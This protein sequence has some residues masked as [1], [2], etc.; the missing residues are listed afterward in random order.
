M[1]PQVKIEFVAS[2]KEKRKIAGIL[3]IPRI[4]R[5]GNL[6]LP[7]EL[8]KAHGKTVPVLWNHEGSPKNASEPVNQSDVIGTMRLF[9]DPDLMQLNY[10]AEVEKDLPDARLHTSL[11]AFFESEDHV[12]G[13][14]R[15]YSIPRGLNFVE[16][17]LTPNPGIP[18]TT[19]KILENFSCK[20]CRVSSLT[21]E[22]SNRCTMSSSDKEYITGT[23]FQEGVK[24]IVDAIGEHF[25]SAQQAQLEKLSEVIGKPAPS[26]MVDDSAKKASKES[27]DRVI[28]FFQ[29][30]KENPK[31]AGFPAVSWNVDK[32]DYL[33]RWGYRAPSGAG[34]A[35][36]EAVTISAGDTGQV[37]SK[38]VLV[39]PGGR[40]KTPVRQYCN[41]SEIPAGNDR[42]HF[43][44]IGAFDFG[45]ITEGTEPT[46]VAQTVS[47]KTATP[48]IRGAVQRVGYSQIESTPF[49]LVD[50][51]NEAM[52]MA[53]IDD[54][55]TD[56]LTTTYD[57]VSPSNWVRADTGA[58][59]T[60]DDVANLTFK[61]E[62]LLAAKRLIAQ[63]GYDV[64]PGN[65]VLFIHPK[66]YQE[67]LLD[68]NLN[69]FYQFARPEVTAT[70][71]LEQLYG[72]DIVIADQVK[73][74]DNTTNDTYRNVLA[75]KGVAFGMA[76][77][78]DV[79]MEAQ[80]RNEVQQ[81]IVSG[82]HRVKS[83]VI[84][85]SASCR[86]SSAQ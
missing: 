32:Q 18:E 76:S 83:V 56:L 48:S 64:S 31:D 25:K 51:I 16:A 39:V 77:A 86:I 79:A 20:Q 75:V 45:A 17:S 72:V 6:Y 5:N 43:Y 36:T 34:G 82:T 23:Q 24:S 19:V 53:A 12:C 7:E 85:E 73:A 55:A 67:L 54:E 11:G 41:F 68:S 46:N 15:C 65:L 9:W 57:A 22:A 4:S 78:R 74:Q 28:E 40:M 10:E 50:A 37:F 30:V 29:R 3:A 2:V 52:V 66:A 21:S 59:I 69:N 26:S 13:S 14:T 27:Y 33:E 60:S 63:Q 42:A 38:Q 1:K 71:L 49:A 70:G 81:V 44:T 62:G 8:A 61:R 47:K 35:K 84:D 80:R 58:G